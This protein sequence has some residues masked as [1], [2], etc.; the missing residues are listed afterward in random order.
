MRDRIRMALGG[1][2]LVTVILDEEDRPLGDAWVELT[3]LAAK[4]R[5]GAPLADAIEADLTEFLDRADNRVLA[6]D[7]RIE[8]AIR[9]LVRQVTVEEIGKKPEVTVVTSRLVAE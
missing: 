4:T 5:K 1:H 3:G 9:K 2:V 7:D 8:E 6:D